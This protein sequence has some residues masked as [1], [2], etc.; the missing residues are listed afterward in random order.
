[1]NK[2]RCNRIILSVSIVAATLVIAIAFYLSY[3][4]I[5]AWQLQLNHSK[6]LK[7]G[8]Y[9]VIVYWRDFDRSSSQQGPSSYAEI[10]VWT[11]DFTYTYQKHSI[12]ETAVVCSGPFLYKLD[13]V[14]GIEI[15]WYRIGMRSI[16]INRFIYFNSQRELVWKSF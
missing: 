12:S 1:M 7:L 14:P 13:G 8:E 11:S 9:E 3:P 10:Y 2:K 4:K 15:C 16:A 5:R 6:Q